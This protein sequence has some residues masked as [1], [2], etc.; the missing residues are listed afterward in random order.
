[1]LSLIVIESPQSRI[2]LPL[3][4]S[5]HAVDS[6]S[7]SNQL[8]MQPWPLR[9]RS[10]CGEKRGGKRQNVGLP[11]APQ[12]HLVTGNANEMPPQSSNEP[13]AHDTTF[14]EKC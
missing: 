9:K 11:V 7:Y 3:D 5:S 14:E 6:L 12:M 1:M 10:E 13:S 4:T 2:Q 8:P